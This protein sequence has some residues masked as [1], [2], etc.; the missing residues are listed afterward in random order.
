MGKSDTNTKNHT[1]KKQ[2][3]SPFTAGDHKGAK[4]RQDSKTKTNTKHKCQ[5]G[6]TKKH[7]LGT[8]SKKFTGGLKHV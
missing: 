6:S 4:N 1:Q 7:F 3:V 8:V 5:K 2:K